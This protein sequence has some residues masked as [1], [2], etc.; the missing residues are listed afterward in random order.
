[1]LPLLFFSAFGLFATGF[2]TDGGF[3][4]ETGTVTI[5]GGQVAPGPDDT[6][7]SAAL[8]SAVRDLLEVGDPTLPPSGTVSCDAAPTVTRDLSVLCRADV[9]RWYGIVRFTD[10]FGSFEV[11]S[12]ESPSWGM[13]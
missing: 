8:T 4:V 9:D 3:G 10:A 13:P 11:L 7:S 12:V 1:M 2:E 6:V 5:G